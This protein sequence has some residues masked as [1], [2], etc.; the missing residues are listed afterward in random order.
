MRDQESRRRWQTDAEMFFYKG[1]LENIIDVQ[2]LSEEGGK[3]V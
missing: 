1:G 2:F 3:S